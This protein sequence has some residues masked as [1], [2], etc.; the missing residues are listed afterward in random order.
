MHFSQPSEWAFAAVAIVLGVWTHLLWDSFTHT[1]GWV[2]RRVDALSAPVV[3]G[4]Y[5]GTVC[6]VLQYLSSAF[7]LI[8]LDPIEVDHLELDGNP[9]NRWIYRRG[10]AGQRTGSEVNP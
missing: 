7:G 10:D 8:V 5:T 9:Q 2:V 6:H 1:G 3:L 4:P